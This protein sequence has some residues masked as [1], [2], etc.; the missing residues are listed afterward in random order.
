MRHFW[1]FFLSD[2]TGNFWRENR[3][4]LSQNRD[5]IPRQNLSPP[6]PAHLAKNEKAKK[7]LADKGMALE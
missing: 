3:E 4:I 5:F 2:R 1:Q 6:C 7:E